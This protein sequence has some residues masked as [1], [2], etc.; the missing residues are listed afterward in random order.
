MLRNSKFVFSS[1]LILLFSMSLR[2]Q[3]KVKLPGGFI[4]GMTEVQL[5][6]HVLRHP[7]IFYFDDHQKYRFVHWDLREVEYNIGLT[8]YR[9]KLTIVSYL[10]SNVFKKIDEPE[11]LNLYYDIVDSL[12]RLNHYIRIEKNYEEKFG[13]KWPYSMGGKNKIKMMVFHTTNSPVNDNIIEIDLTCTDE[14]YG[15]DFS[16]YGEGLNADATLTKNLFFDQ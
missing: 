6:D 3:V 2:A 14:L 5:K 10:G 7:G 16:Y 11:L 8:L 9:G 12:K 13:V 4:T 15:I 1:I